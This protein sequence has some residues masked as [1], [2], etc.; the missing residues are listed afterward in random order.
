MIAKRRTV[1][2]FDV[3]LVVASQNCQLSQ[4]SGRSCSRNAELSSRLDARLVLKLRKFNRRRDR[5]VLVAKRRTVVTFGRAS[6]PRIPKLSTVTGIGKVVLAKRR[7]LL[8]VPLVLEL[9][10]FNQL[11]QRWGG[12]R[13]RNAELSS[14][15]DLP[16]ER[17]EERRG[18][19]RRGEER[20]GE[21]RGERRKERK[22][23]GKQ[24]RGE[25]RGKTRDEGIENRGKKR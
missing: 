5:G 17:G 12:S 9:Q 15:L 6:C 1:V 20:R 24:R 11:S 4:G 13:S 25:R 16:L 18:E 3:P 23:E 10:D 22:K 14:L 7:T 21:E 19:E 2:T 8:D